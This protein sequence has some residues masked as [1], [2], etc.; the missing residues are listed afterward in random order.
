MREWLKIPD[1]RKINIFKEIE[2]KSKLKPI[3]IEKDWW[4]VQTPRLIFEMEIAP[5]CGFD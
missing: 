5:L 1:S 4:V 3:A 2:S